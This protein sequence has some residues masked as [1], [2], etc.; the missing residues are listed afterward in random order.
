MQ[1]FRGVQPVVSTTL[2]WDLDELGTLNRKKMATLVGVAPLNCDSGRFRGRRR[3][4]GGRVIVR[5]KL[6]M[7]TVASLRHN[8]V[9]K[10]FYDRLIGAGNPPKL[11]LIACMRKIITILNAM[12]RNPTY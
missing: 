10:D 7:A 8:P 1:S 2:V 4:S 9:M 5:R 11:A 6:Y 12:I 3:I